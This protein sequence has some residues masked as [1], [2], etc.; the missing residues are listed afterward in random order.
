M[1][2]ATT[3]YEDMLDRQ[4]ENMPVPKNVQQISS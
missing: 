3:K 1:N 2:T 4:K